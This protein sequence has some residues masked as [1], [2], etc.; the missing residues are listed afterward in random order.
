MLRVN[1]V[2][3]SCKMSLPMRYLLN[4][5]GT[6]FLLNS[7]SLTVHFPYLSSKAFAMN[8][9]EEDDDSSSSKKQKEEESTQAS[10]SFA[11]T[12]SSSSSSSEIDISSLKKKIVSFNGENWLVS[13]VRPLESGYNILML[14]KCNKFEQIDPSSPTLFVSTKDLQITHSKDNL[15]EILITTKEKLDIFSNNHYYSKD[16]SEEL[17]SAQTQLRYQ[18]LSHSFTTNRSLYNYE[19]HPEFFLTLNGLTASGHWMDVGSGEGLALENF[20]AG[21]ES[22]LYKN[23]NSYFDSIKTFSPSDQY[24][25]NIETIGLIMNVLSKPLADKPQVTG[26]TYFSERDV[27]SFEGKLR[28]FR[29][30]Y[31][32]EI[33]PTE[34]GQADL[35]SDFYG[36]FAYSPRLDHVIIQYLSILKESGSAYIFIDEGLP[37]KSIDP[38]TSW[39]KVVTLSGRELPLLDWISKISSIESQILYDSVTKPNR[40]PITLRLRRK[41]GVV[42]RIPKLELIRSTNGSPPIRIFR[43]IE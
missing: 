4:I 9:R 26:V 30:R 14:F 28:Y 27:P 22:L 6:L 43:E 12:D 42:P 31:F 1:V 3:H 36:A 7:F 20:L 33:P 11:E 17:F 38:S 37:Q 35:I 32:E 29:G 15:N 21:E 34:L 18:L 2:P 24:L 40:I 41:K 5:L 39:T 25:N 19:L 10:T 13:S 8:N 23:L 16:K